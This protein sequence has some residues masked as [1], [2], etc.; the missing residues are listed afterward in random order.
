MS[1]NLSQIK[2]SVDVAKERIS[3]W[4]HD[5]GIQSRSYQQEAIDWGLYKEHCVYDQG[6]TFVKTTPRG[7]IA[8]EMGRQNDCYA[9][10][11]RWKSRGQHTYSCTLGTS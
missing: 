5:F 8:D 4:M 2:N 10:Y 7:L 6:G 3:Q 1:L 11:L 9:F